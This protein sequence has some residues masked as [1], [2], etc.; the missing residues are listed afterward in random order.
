MN[1]TQPPAGRR[2]FA[3]LASLR[4]AVVLLGLFAACLAGATLLE[5]RYGAFAAGELV[6]RTWWFALLLTL[7]AGNVLCAALKKY[8]WKRYQIGFLVTHTGL[9]VLL[10]GGLLTALAGVEGQMVL[11]DTADPVLQARLGL[12]NRADAILLSNAHTLDVYLLKRPLSDA[13]ALIRFVA[14]VDGGEEPADVRDFVAASWAL[15]F[16]PGPFPWYTD[17][18]VRPSLPWQVRLL[19]RLAD[20][21]PGWSHDLGRATLTVDNFYPHAAYAPHADPPF[22][23][24]A[25][26]PAGEAASLPPALR[27]RFGGDGHTESFWVGLSRP[28]ARVRLGADLYLVRYRP[29]TRPVGFTLTLRRARQVR[30]P[31]TDRPAWFQSDVGVSAAGSP[32]REHRI[33]MNHP[34]AEGP[35]R[36]YQAN[37]QLLRDPHTLEPLRAAG[38]PVSLSGLAVSHD[39]GLWPKYAG[40][41]IVVLGIAIMFYMRAY[42]FRPRRRGAAPP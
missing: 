17:E 10:L 11:V 28:A 27:C 37:Y 31:G 35:Y 32:P 2:L 16:R 23:P 14:A 30:H 21:W 18:Y 7:L 34:L 4:L 24:R 36:V 13:D 22:T 42:F 15:P 9:L 33:V 12:G 38:R 26:P 29:Q 25:D 3:A 39:P 6:Y 41:L 40:S 1:P 20:P 19:H 5:A 8:P